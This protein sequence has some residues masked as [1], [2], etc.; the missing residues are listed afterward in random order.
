MIASLLAH[1]VAL[2]NIHGAFGPQ[3]FILLASL[4]TEGAAHDSVIFTELR[5]NRPA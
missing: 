1:C 3:S 5:S 2:L 4:C